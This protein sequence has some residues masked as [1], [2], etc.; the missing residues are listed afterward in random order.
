MTMFSGDSRRRASGSVLTR[1]FL[2]HDLDAAQLPLGPNCILTLFFGFPIHLSMSQ[3]S[4]Q[5]CAEISN[6]LDRG[7]TGE[8]KPSN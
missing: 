1:L 6:F 4:C 2:W 3:Y 5:G 7:R 8:G